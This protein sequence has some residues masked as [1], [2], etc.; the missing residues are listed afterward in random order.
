[1]FVFV[2][3]R[4]Q[5]CLSDRV[6]LS[7]FGKFTILVTKL[8]ISPMAFHFAFS[9]TFSKNL[10]GMC[11]NNGHQLFTAAYEIRTKWPC[12]SLKISWIKFQNQVCFPQ[13]NLTRKMQITYLQ[14]VIVKTWMSIN[15]LSH[16]IT[17]WLTHSNKNYFWESMEEYLSNETVLRL[18][19]YKL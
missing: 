5:G 16:R 15:I 6:T 1:M 4:T 8:R 12:T 3:S 17:H 14:I 9:H 11:H 13:S 10:S 19:I 2:Q 7:T 18:I